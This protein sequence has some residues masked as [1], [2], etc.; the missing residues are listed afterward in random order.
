MCRVRCDRN[1]TYND[2]SRRNWETDEQNSAEA[3][4]NSRLQQEAAVKQVLQHLHNLYIG[5]DSDV[6]LTSHNVP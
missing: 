5:M 3:E 1:S 6:P 4:Q 2:R